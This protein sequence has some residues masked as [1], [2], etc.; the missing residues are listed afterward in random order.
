MGLGLAWGGLQMRRGTSLFTVAEPEEE[1]EYL[2]VY[3]DEDG[4]EHEITVEEAERLEADGAVTVTEHVDE[5][6]P[7]DVEATSPDDQEEV[8]PEAG[9]VPTAEEDRVGSA[10]TAADIVAETVPVGPEPEPIQPEPAQP[11][12]EPA[13]PAEEADAVYVYV[14]DDGVEHEITAEEAERLAAEEGLEIVDADPEEG[15]A[16]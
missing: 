12:L 11:E 5:P 2:Y 9:P 8:A 3:V 6:V 1:V 15:D 4:V 16:R 13:Q 14:D 10:P 7:A